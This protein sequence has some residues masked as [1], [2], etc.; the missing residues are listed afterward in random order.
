MAFNITSFSSLFNHHSHVQA[1]AIEIITNSVWNMHRLFHVCSDIQIQGINNEPIPSLIV[2]FRYNFFIIKVINLMLLHTNSIYPHQTLLITMKRNWS[3]LTT[4]KHT[5]AHVCYVYIINRTS[6]PSSYNIFP[7][8][9]S[10]K[11]TPFFT[12][13]VLEILRRGIN[14]V[15]SHK[16]ISRNKRKRPLKSHSLFR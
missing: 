8:N 1:S 16:K 14:K 6:E 11:Q 5:I 12:C 9:R 2:S 4:Q 10:P 15:T 7:H 3:K 13:K